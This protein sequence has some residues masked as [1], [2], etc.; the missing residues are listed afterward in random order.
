MT[1]DMR[2]AFLNWMDNQL[3]LIRTGKKELCDGE[4]G[5]DFPAVDW[6]EQAWNDFNTQV[7]IEKDLLRRS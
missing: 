2:Q 5:A 3:E 7:I 1:E 6:A 4:T